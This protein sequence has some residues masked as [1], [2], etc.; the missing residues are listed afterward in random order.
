M[1]LRS[2]NAQSNGIL[3][4][5]TFIFSTGWYQLS[6]TYKYVHSCENWEI[7]KYFKKLLQTNANV[8]I[9]VHA[10]PFQSVF[11]SKMQF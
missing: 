10:T 8:K 3:K 6:L 5:E 7:K 11:F 4:T 9:R 1:I 2:F